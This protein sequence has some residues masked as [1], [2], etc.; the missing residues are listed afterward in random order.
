MYQG[1]IGTSKNLQQA[2][3]MFRRAIDFGSADARQNLSMLYQPAKPARKT[4]AY[5]EYR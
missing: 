3:V 2:D 5:P 1:G 4:L